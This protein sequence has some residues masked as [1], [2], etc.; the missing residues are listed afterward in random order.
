[1][2]GAFKYAEQHMENIQRFGRFPARNAALGRQS[3]AQKLDFLNQ[4]R[5]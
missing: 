5:R 3:T 4:Q 1:M 2:T